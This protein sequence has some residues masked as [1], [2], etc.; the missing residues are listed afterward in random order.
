MIFHDFP[1]TTRIHR[2][3][4]SI[5]Q[6]KDFLMKSFIYT[7]IFPDLPI[8]PAISPRFSHVFH[9]AHGAEAANT[10]VPR[11]RRACRQARASASAL[12]M[13]SLASL[14]SREGGSNGIPN[15]L[16][17]LNYI[18]KLPLVNWLNWL[19]W[20]L[21]NDVNWLNWDLPISWDNNWD[22]VNLLNEARRENWP[23][24]PPSHLAHLKWNRVTW[25]L[26]IND[27]GLLVGG[28][29]PSEKY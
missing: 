18:I 20:D 10:R 12:Q 27:H 23:G 2:Q 7:M 13:A 26:L 16:Q 22:F 11:A 15:P 24:K 21:V 6:F 5:S 1:T 3:F 9:R 19:N 4:P 29:N 14:F 28:L 17:V 25:L 8:N